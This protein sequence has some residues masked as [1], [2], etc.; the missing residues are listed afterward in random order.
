M[1]QKDAHIQRQMIFLLR[2][3]QELKTQNQMRKIL[4]EYIENDA[5]FTLQFLISAN[6]FSY[7]KKVGTG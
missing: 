5:G 1:N 2:Y 3:R 6:G 4:L 7:V